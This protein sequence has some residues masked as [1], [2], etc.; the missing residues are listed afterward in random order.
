M[1]ISILPAA[2]LVLLLLPGAADA[3]GSR[4][5]LTTRFTA[6]GR[7]AGLRLATTTPLPGGA[8]LRYTL[9]DELRVDAAL[10]PLPAG[11]GCARA[12]DSVA[13]DAGTAAFA[14][15]LPGFTGDGLAD[16]L[17]V[18]RDDAV[19]LAHPGGTAYGRHLRMAGA[20]SGKPV[21]SHHL[22]YGLG[23]YLV[24]VRATFPPGERRDSLVEQFAREF[25]EALTRPAEGARAC[26]GGPADPENVRLAVDS[27]AGIAEVRAR[28]EPGLRALGFAVAPERSGADSVVTAPVEGWPSGIDYGAWARERSPGFVVGVRLEERGAGT[29]ILVS[30]EALCAPAPGAEDPKAQELALELETA[31]QVLGRVDPT[32]AR[33]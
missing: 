14:R 5:S 17:A 15:G 1:R 11:A 22:L 26:P 31:K 12:C 7:V 23:G 28:V 33:P 3:Q 32:R 27:R 30:A 13:V 4:S 10:L 21:H 16:S 19:R 2:A 8:Q 25:V 6:P 24:R 18:E 9:G 20:R 29:R